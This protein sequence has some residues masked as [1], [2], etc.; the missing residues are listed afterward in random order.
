MMTEENLRQ[1]VGLFLG[2]GSI[3][4]LSLL[5]LHWE[6][7]AAVMDAI[8]PDDTMVVACALAVQADAIWTEDKHFLQQSIVK[9]VTT[10]EL[11]KML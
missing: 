2:Q 6:K 8:D 9:V 5:R 3:V 10:E 4:P 1:L 11:S 7:A